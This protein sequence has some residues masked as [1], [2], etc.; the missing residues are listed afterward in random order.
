MRFIL[1]I[2]GYTANKPKNNLENSLTEGLIFYY[3]SNRM[4]SINMKDE[5]TIIHVR[6]PGAVFT[7]YFI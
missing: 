5:Q 6:V 7:I 3:C 2:L 4:I 1:K